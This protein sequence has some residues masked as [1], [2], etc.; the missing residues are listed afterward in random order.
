MENVIRFETLEIRVK[1][2]LQNVITFYPALVQMLEKKLGMT[3]V[4]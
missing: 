4:V 2:L 3:I 1:E